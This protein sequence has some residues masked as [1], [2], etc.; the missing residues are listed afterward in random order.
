MPNEGGFS[1]A[2]LAA[3]EWSRR[4]RETRRGEEDSR[5][6]RDLDSGSKRRL[7]NA[8]W[9]DDWDHA[10]IRR[11]TGSSV[12]DR[13]GRRQ[14]D[15]YFNRECEESSHDRRPRYTEESVPEVKVKEEEEGSKLSLFTE[16]RRHV[17]QLRQ[18][19]KLE[20]SLRQTGKTGDEDDVPPDPRNPLLAAYERPPRGR[21]SRRRLPRDHWEDTWDH[22]RFRERSLSP[23]RPCISDE[24]PVHD[25]RAGSWRAR[26]G[27]VY[28][29]PPDEEEEEE[30]EASGSEVKREKR[31]YWD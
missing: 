14:Q 11:R 7:G 30:A 17:E 1:S 5:R 16:R 15:R 12:A 27:G 13:P 21:E 8:Q 29:P 19:I 20:Q 28:L 26:A 22:D 24:G 23:E 3:A 10:R 9:S 6:R 18:E 31:R 4:W 2:E 25:T